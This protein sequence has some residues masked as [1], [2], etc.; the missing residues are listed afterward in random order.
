MKTLKQFLETYLAES[1]P[2][3]V[4]AHTDTVGRNR[5]QSHDSTTKTW[6]SEHDHK[7]T[8]RAFRKG[9]KD[10]GHKNIRGEKSGDDNTS[11]LYS[12]D[13]N[14]DRKSHTID[15]WSDGGKHTHELYTSLT[16]NHH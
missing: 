16:A 15:T 13:K 8:M 3:D 5:G 14:G 1:I 12:T 9:L 10:A 6:E 11:Y 4:I 7:A 2:D